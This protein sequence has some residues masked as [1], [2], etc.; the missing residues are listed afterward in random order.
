MPVAEQAGQ[1]GGRY[2]LGG[3]SGKRIRLGRLADPGTGNSLVVTIAHGLFGGPFPEEPPGAG[4]GPLVRE[5]SAA[6]ANAI[7]TSPGLV[8]HLAESF[9][10]R[11]APGLILCLDWTSMFRSPETE[12]GFAEGR[13]SLLAHVEDAVRL[14]A[15]AVMT[16]LFL[17]LGDAAAEARA[18]ELNG[19]I[20][21]ECERLGVVRIIETMARGERVG[22]AATKPEYVRLHTRIA[23]EVGCDLIKTEWT[24][25]AASFRTVVEHCPVP[26]L[27]AGG[28]RTPDPRGALAICEGAMRAGAAGIVFGR[29]VV[30]AAAPGRMTRA[31]SRIIHDGWSSER[32]AAELG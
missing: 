10:G 1:F 27:V 29:N 16:Y 5:V 32:A 8:G 6:G 28:P 31:L 21:R 19:A 23:A 4:Y 13:Q 26:I 14:G 11:G 7:I 24:G 20:S 12:L 22:A 30:Q 9:V 15:D 17:G 3:A 25:D 18:V 2:P